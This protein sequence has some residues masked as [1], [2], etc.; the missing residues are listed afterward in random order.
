MI[1]SM[2]MRWAGHVVYTG[3]M[4]N[5]ILVGNLEGRDYAEELSIKGKM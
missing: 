3:Q 2:S 1:K 4:R 5:K